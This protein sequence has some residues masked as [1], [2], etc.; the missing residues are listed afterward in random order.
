MWPPQSWTGSYGEG[1]NFLIGE[2][3][4]LYGLY[5]LFWG[6]NMKLI[7]LEG[8]KSKDND[9]KYLDIHCHQC[10]RTAKERLSEQIG[11]ID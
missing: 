4:I 3:G 7:N 6:I 10:L 2:N 9:I 11:G 8:V 1:D 5:S